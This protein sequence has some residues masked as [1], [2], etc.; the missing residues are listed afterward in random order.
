MPRR[1][2]YSR[3][4]AIVKIVLPLV[5]LGILST[6]FLLSRPEPAG[7][8]LPFS[9][10]DPQGVTRLQGLNRPV[11]TAVN[12]DGAVVRLT[13]L[14]LTPDDDRADLSHGEDLAA[15]ITRPDG[16]VMDLTAP[17][18]TLDDR[19]DRARLTGGVR[20]TT[21]AGYVARMPS[22]DL[23]TDL[24]RVT[25]DGPVTATGP[26]GDLTAGTMDLSMRKG[27]G[28]DMVVLFTGGVRLIYRPQSTE[29]P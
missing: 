10:D 23:E 24:S 16:T 13:A 8:A 22:V 9:E 17:R 20:V 4:I 3:A 25:S 29:A 15:R 12:D 5:A 26:A 6:L 19:S 14:R 28:G 7:D 1:D 27:G 2:G 21:S 11:Y 18:G